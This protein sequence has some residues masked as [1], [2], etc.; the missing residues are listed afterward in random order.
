MW[1][2]VFDMLDAM[3]QQL[4]SQPARVRQKSKIDATF[5]PSGPTAAGSDDADVALLLLERAQGRYTPYTPLPPV[6][7]AVD[8][9]RRLAGL[10]F[11]SPADEG[12][13]GYGILPNSVILSCLP[14]SEREQWQFMTPRPPVVA[15]SLFHGKGAYLKLVTGDVFNNTPEPIRGKALQTRIQYIQTS[16]C[17]YL[18]SGVTSR[19][20]LL[21]VQIILL[22]YVLSEIP[23][24]GHTLADPAFRPRTP[25]AVGAV[26]RVLLYQVHQLATIPGGRAHC[27][28][29]LPNLC[30]D[31]TDP[32]SL[33][34]IDFDR[35]RSFSGPAPKCMA[36]PSSPPSIVRAAPLTLHQLACCILELADTPE[37]LNE[38]FLI[39]SYYARFLGGEMADQVSPIL[40]R[41][42]PDSNQSPEAELDW[43]PEVEDQRALDC[44]QEALAWVRQHGGVPGVQPL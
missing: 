9:L 20:D 10:P 1:F 27:D 41:L 14:A 30:W 2:D 28:L 34:I 8:S 12:L 3:Q 40:E 22:P 35:V 42:L 11:E 36:A 43:S 32:T 37:M 6:D 24:F 15:R 29:R 33:R 21:Q 7:R 5:V 19:G 13:G 38:Q 39:P 4:D 18:S 25:A 44:L 16:N 26:A 31:G 17:L 23:D